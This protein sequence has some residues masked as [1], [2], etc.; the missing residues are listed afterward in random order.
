MTDKS[1]VVAEYKSLWEHAKRRAD[2][3]RGIASAMGYEPNAHDNVKPKDKWILDRIAKFRVEA[4][5]SLPPA[6]AQA[7]DMG[8]LADRFEALLNTCEY[9]QGA[10]FTER[11]ERV[12]DFLLAR[13][14]IILTA[15][16]TQPPATYEDQDAL[17]GYRA[18]IAWVGADSWDGCSDCIEILKAAVGADINYGQSPDET[19]FHLKRIRAISGKPALPNPTSPIAG[20]ALEPVDTC[21]IPEVAAMR[22]IDDLRSFYGSVTILPDNEEASTEGEQMAVDCCGDWTDWVDR[23]FYGESIVQCLAKAVEAKRLAQI[24]SMKENKDG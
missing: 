5:A 24:D 15:L 1:S 17:A 9:A 11:A 7:A 4:A 20:S 3:W 16:R 18:A 2:R 10:L 12:V 19:A 14:N 6:V 23:R 13:R 8:V 22:F 21:E